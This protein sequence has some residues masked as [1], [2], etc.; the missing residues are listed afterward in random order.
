MKIHF[1]YQFRPIQSKFMAIRRTKKDQ[2]QIHWIY[3]FAKI[4]RPN[5][6]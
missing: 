2:S 6:I 4:S 1:L 3:Y 5:H